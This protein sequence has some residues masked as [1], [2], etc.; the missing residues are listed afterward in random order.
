MTEN[1]PKWLEWHFLREKLNSLLSGSWPAA[2][3]RREEVTLCFSE[4]Y[5]HVQLD[6]VN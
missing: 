6:S 1:I 4:E 2:E 3:T 5:V